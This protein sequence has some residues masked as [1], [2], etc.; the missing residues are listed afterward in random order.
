M[1]QIKN[2]TK[3]YRSKKKNKC[4]A[5]D[6]INLTLENKGLVFVLGKSGSGKST[7]LN[8]LGGLDNIT[9]GTII[10]D[11]NDI[12][13]LKEKEYANY[14]NTEIGFVF[15]D[16]HLIEELTVKENILLSLNLRGIEDE[17]KVSEALEKVDLKGYENRYPNELS[18]GERQRVAIARAIIKSPRII[19]AD[20]PTGNLDT[21][22]SKLIIET[23]K[24]VSRDCLIII[25]SHNTLDAYKYS[26]RIIELVNGKII[27]DL[28]RNLDFK[29]ELYVNED[30]IYYPIDKVLEDKDIELFNDNKTKKIIKNKDK[31]NETRNIEYSEENKEIINSNLSFKSVFRFCLK[32]LNSKYLKIV[33]SS[34]M[35]SIILIILLFSMNIVMFNGGEVLTNELTLADEKAVILEKILPSEKQDQYDEVFRGKIDEDDINT[36]IESGYKGDIYEV[37]SHTTVITNMRN[38]AGEKKNIFSNSIYIQE[39]VGLIIVDE[40]YLIEKFGKDNEVKYVAKLDSYNEA[41]VII[42]D[43]VADCIL[44]NNPTYQKYLLKEN[45]YDYL[46]GQYY[47]HDYKRTYINA[48]I[49]TGYK[50]KYKEIFNSANIDLES[51]KEN[52]ELIT[53]FS[54]DVYTRLGMTYTLNKNF[55]EDYPKYETNDYFFFYKAFYDDKELSEI[56]GSFAFL[57]K[58]GKLKDNQVTMSY[59]KYNDI[60]GTSYNMFNA[61]TFQSHTCR[62][63]FTYFNDFDEEFYFDEEVEIV[64]FHQ[65]NNGI[66]MSETL[67]R[68][69]YSN[70]IYPFA[71]LFDG[72]EGI[73]NVINIYED[74]NYDMNSLVVE[75]LYT[76]TKAVE[77]FVPIFELVAIVLC[78]GVIFILVNFSSKMI[79]DKYHEIGVMKA[80]G[81][82]NS[83]IVNIFGAQILLISILT[84]ILTL[85]GYYVFID[86]ANVVL[87]ESLQALASSY[88]LLDLTFLYF[89]FDIA[90]IG[91]G[92][93]IALSIVSLLLPMV[94][95]KNIKP[96]KIIKAKE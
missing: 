32:F 1:I 37:Y 25:V 3:I 21:Q 16:Y 40:V 38:Q 10:V 55:L 46:L 15:Q 76:M 94:R 14:R 81:A 11:G 30:I 27:R 48:I 17:S 47:A 61:Y 89:R 78:V 69:G 64:G 67:Y 49:D 23:L 65:T 88:T 4:K 34:F 51:L 33:F 77:V 80:L 56:L 9:G 96:V 62:I 79:K 72:V 35:S 22:T 12:S 95:I 24:E 5:L 54:N 66:T 70:Q 13:N 39:T 42:T 93:I 43:Y 58:N 2:L 20:E 86:F 41:G 26:D 57:D 71:L 18:G 83:S 75:S 19:L 90:L 53:S 52:K 28:S 50:E 74:K 36:F 31:F 85:I 68:K 87:I 60:F 8:L 82:K 63:R 29:D 91:I 73:D 84:I 44:L 59:Q 6:N 45:K 7:L 92:L